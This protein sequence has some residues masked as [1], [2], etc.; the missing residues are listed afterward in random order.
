MAI[1]SNWVLVLAEAAQAQEF[2]YIRHSVKSAKYSVIPKH[3]CGGIE[4]QR[5]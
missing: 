2:P 3:R 1:W 5:C 4:C